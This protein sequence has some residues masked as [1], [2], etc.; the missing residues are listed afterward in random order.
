MAIPERGDV[1]LADLGW[2]AKTRP[3][4][5]LSV[6]YSDSDYALLAVVPHTTTTRGSRFEVALEVR[7]LKSGAFNVQGILAVPPIKCIKKL[8]TLTSDQ[9]KTVESTVAGWLGITS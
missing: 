1:W 7:S 3:V 9:L 8:T 2:S 4:L 5:I 6:P